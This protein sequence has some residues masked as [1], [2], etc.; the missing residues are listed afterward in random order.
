MIDKI[1]EG[2]EEMRPNVQMDGGDI[3][4]VSYKD[5][6]V[7]VK[8]LGAC[9]GCPLSMYTLKMGIEENLKERI[10]EIVEVIAVD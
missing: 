7:S 8:L 1:Q 4:F 9:V 5:G 6:I 3:Q 2:L 10:P